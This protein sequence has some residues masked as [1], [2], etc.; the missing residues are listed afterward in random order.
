[1]VTI[2]IIPLTFVIVFVMMIFGMYLYHNFLLLLNKRHLEVW[3]EL[4]SPKLFGNNSIENNLKMLM[5]LK[6]KEY[7]KFNDVR[8]TR[9]AQSLWKYNIVYLIVFFSVVIWFVVS[10]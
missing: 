3:R 8:L 4:G 10:I 1:M 6:N 9:A 5:F 7:S 2:E